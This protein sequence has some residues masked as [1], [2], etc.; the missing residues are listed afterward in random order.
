MTS[1]KE[2]KG[3]S[4]CDRARN[5][6][7]TAVI[8]AALAIGAIAAV[9]AETA[10]DGAAAKKVCSFWGKYEGD[11]LG[12]AGE[13]YQAFTY[14]TLYSVSKDN[15]YDSFCEH[16][17]ASFDLRVSFG[18]YPLYFRNPFYT[19]WTGNAIVWWPVLGD[20]Q[21]SAHL[22]YLND[23]FLQAEPEN[24]PDRFR[25][26]AF[27]KP[28][29]GSLL[30][31][32]RGSTSSADYHEYTILP[33]LNNDVFYL[34]AKMT[35]TQNGFIRSTFM[36]VEDY[37][38]FV[39]LTKPLWDYPFYGGRSVILETANELSLSAVEDPT[40]MFED[41]GPFI[42]S[43]HDDTPAYGSNPEVH[44]MIGGRSNGVDRD[45]GA[46]VDRAVFTVFRFPYPEAIFVVR[47]V[48]SDDDGAPIPELSC[49]FKGEEPDQR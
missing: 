22:S 8:C 4:M 42:R 26:P 21:I 35:Q 15:R 32:G 7:T 20:A 14:K 36:E 47:F 23:E 17:K 27:R 12:C 29:T 9:H 24:I 31:R 43:E 1:L 38:R 40:I 37:E 11:W 19:G 10:A 25:S 48:V 46:R 6:R 30:Y 13:A 39:P 3:I 49:W 34:I 28:R 2:E 44:F 5:L 41:G 33:F 18:T 45:K 16:L